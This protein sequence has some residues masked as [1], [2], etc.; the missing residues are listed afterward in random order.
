MSTKFIQYVMLGV[1][2]IIVIGLIYFDMQAQESESTPRE[3]YYRGLYDACVSL[4]PGSPE[5]R[6]QRCYK[7][8]INAENAGFY[9]EPSV[10]WEWPL[11]KLYKAPTPMPVPTVERK[12]Y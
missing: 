9:E 1:T 11:A 5:E 4:L 2:V 3:E 12:V 6:L 7:G 10:G 8:V